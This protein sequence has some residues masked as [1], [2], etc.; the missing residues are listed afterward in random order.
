MTTTQTE[1]LLTTKEP[2]TVETRR[3]LIVTAKR[4]RSG[5]VMAKGYANATQAKK[6]A[7]KLGAGWIVYGLFP[8]YV[9]RAPVE[10]G[11]N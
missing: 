11:R 8:F 2:L 10:P 5:L 3:G 9:G 4:T 6:A 7:E 1:K